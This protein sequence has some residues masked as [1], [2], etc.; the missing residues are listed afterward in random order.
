MTTNGR[1]AALWRTYVKKDALNRAWRVF[2][3]AI[4]YAIVAS[5]LDLAYQVVERQL[6]EAAAGQALDWV[7]TWGWFRGGLGAALLMP[8]IA[9]LHRKKLDPS[10]IPSAVPPLP[11]GVV[12]ERR[13]TPPDVIVGPSV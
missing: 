2:M 11:P 6:G 10:P 4:G 8:I 1:A 9:Y 12:A 3:Q 13:G 7:E 5:V